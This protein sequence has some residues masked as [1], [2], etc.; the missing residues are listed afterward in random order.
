VASPPPYRLGTPAPEAPV[1][2]LQPPPLLFP[3][4]SGWP[5]VPTAPPGRAT[6]EAIQQVRNAVGYYWVVLVLELVLGALSGALT[7]ISIGGG[8][9]TLAN[10]GTSSAGHSVLSG[11]AAAT[12]S[13]VAGI[14]A[15]AVL[16]LVIYSW[17]KWREGATN[18]ERS[19]GEFGPEPAS[20][21]RRA[22]GDVT[23]ATYV[24]IVTLV[25]AIVVAGVIAAIVF[26]S[27]LSN[28]YPNGTLKPNAPSSLSGGDL[29]A[30]QSTAVVLAIVA[31]LLSILLYAFATRSHVDTIAPYAPAD[32]RAKADLG[33][34]HVLLGAALGFVNLVGLFVPYAGVVAVVPAAFLVY[35]YREIM[36]AFDQVLRA[37]TVQ[38]VPGA[39]R[40]ERFLF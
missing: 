3:G 28:R 36:G 19:A 26:A 8:A 35:G 20:I 40:V 15:L 27:V 16:I 21:A 37:P 31:T 5:S 22:R 34:S 1:A 7:G 29:A 38:P 18:L 14:G 10:V 30:I 13:S 11:G 2:A 25:A 24:F 4:A 39:R 32:V 23:S 6:R 33:R 17:V 9:G 12:Y